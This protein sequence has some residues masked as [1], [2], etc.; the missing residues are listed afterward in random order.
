MA[1]LFADC[2]SLTS[3]DLTNFDTMNVNQM[4]YMFKG[5]SGLNSLNISN[6]NTSK[7]SSMGF[8]FNDCK[9]LTS[10]DLS[11][12]N[13]KS[14]I[15]DTYTWTGIHYIFDGCSSL[16]YINLKNAKPPTPPGDYIFTDTPDNLVVCTDE[17][18]WGII[19]AG[20]SSVKELIINCSIFLS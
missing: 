13:T 4:S 20:I 8:M 7:V 9:N 1:Y 17:R 14:L 11:N 16:S 15:S 10:L 6:F 12:F 5:C 2:S 19:L 18:K 3:L